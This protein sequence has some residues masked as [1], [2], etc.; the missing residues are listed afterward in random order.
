M[1]RRG[2]LHLLQGVVLLFLVGACS[3]GLTD[4]EWI[5][6]QANYVAVDDAASTLGMT[7]SYSWNRLP[8]DQMRMD[9]GYAATCHAA[10]SDAGSPGGPADAKAKTLTDAE[11][12]YCAE[13]APYW[14]VEDEAAKLGQKRVPD[15]SGDPSFKR[16]EETGDASLRTDGDY[17]RACQAACSAR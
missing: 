14:V 8:L 6:C 9:C 2:L 17:L 3:G 13:D 4:G 1:L 11:Y 5:R 10:Y 16:L 15:P 12:K 7:T